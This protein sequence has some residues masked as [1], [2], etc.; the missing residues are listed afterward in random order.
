GSLYYADNHFTCR[1]IKGNGDFWYHDGIELGS[2][3]EAQGNIHTQSPNFC[4]NL[5]ETYSSSRGR[6]SL[7]HLRL[8]YSYT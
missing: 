2:N 1:I 5:L 6:C 4:G 8:D 7:C 3:V